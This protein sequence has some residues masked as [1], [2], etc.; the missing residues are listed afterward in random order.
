[1]LKKKWMKEIVLLSFNDIEIHK[2]TLQLAILNTQIGGTTCMAI[3]L[4]MATGIMPLS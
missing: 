4:K 2:T 1:M 3:I